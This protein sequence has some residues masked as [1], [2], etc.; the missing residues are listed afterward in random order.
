MR[1]SAWLVSLLAVGFVPYG[2]SSERGA[3]K[4]ISGY[5]T[6]DAG[7]GGTSA[8]GIFAGSGGQCSDEGA[9]AA[10]LHTI[11]FN[12]PNIYFVFDA[13][14]SMSEPASGKSGQNRYA[15][16]RNT[17]ITLVR[18]LGPMINVGA[19]VFPSFAGNCNP[20]GET[21][22]VT[23]G[24]PFDPNASFE[25]PTLTAFKKA[26]QRVPNGGTPTAQSLKALLPKLKLLTGHSIVLVLTDGGPNCNPG[27]SCTPDECGPVIDNLC[28][29]N[30]GCC[31][32]GYPGGGPVA[33]VDR[34]NSVAAVKAIHDLGID[35]Y[36]IGVT[37]LQAY[38]NV[39]DEMAVAG[40]VPNPTGSKYTE[41]KDLDTLGQVFA[42]IA[43]G[44]ISCDI[45]LDKPPQ[46][47]DYTNVF[48]GCDVVT[49]DDKNGWS[50]TD[51][52]TVTLHGDACTKLRSG[53]VSKVD[54]VTGCPTE[55]PK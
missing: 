33:C 25:G 1:A 39:L 46:M 23:P 4:G 37:D 47:K 50:W 31:D 9:C 3:P 21:M 10:E 27:A 40:G 52:D 2:C 55:T 16:V 45:K 53:S 15:A 54:V 7:S 11:K 13:S 43:A 17:A 41:V 44:A 34:A 18:S 28:A 49:F 30:E 42:K 12:A 38:G 48:F 14:G 6:T 22:A 24:D 26:T 36:I 5:P 29:P 20:G 35:V 51:D 19:A 32:P 8:T